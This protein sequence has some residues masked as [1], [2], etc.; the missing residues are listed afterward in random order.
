MRIAVLNQPDK[1]G[2]VAALIEGLRR[3]GLEPRYSP[4][5]R[6]DV[7]V[8][9]CWGWRR[10][11][12]YRKRGHHVLML[13]RGYVGDRMAWLSLGWDGL[14]GRARFPVVDDG[15]ERWRRYFGGMLQPWRDGGDF[16]VLMGQVAS[17]AAVGS[18]DI[19]AW[20]L[21]ASARLRSSSE[22]TRAGLR[23]RSPRNDKRYAI[24]S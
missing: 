17:D 6:D 11:Q 12:K 19:Q 24:G 3:H 20:Y 23:P 18:C 1:S 8:V 21:E 4:V 22:N 16:I 5:I 15:G 7:D 13:E 2:W 10:G 9:V 14:N